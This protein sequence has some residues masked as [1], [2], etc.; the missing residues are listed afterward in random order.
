MTRFLSPLA[1]LL[2]CVS[3]SGQALAQGALYDPT[4]P[5][6]GYQPAVPAE[7]VAP[8]EPAAPAVPPVQIKRLDPAPAAGRKGAAAASAAASAPGRVISVN[9]EGV[10]VQSGASRQTLSAQSAV[11]KKQVSEK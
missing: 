8:A 4:Q 1:T 6:P 7:K 5:P 11:Q 3:A 10:V 9:A 2:L